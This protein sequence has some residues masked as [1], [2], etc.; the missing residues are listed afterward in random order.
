ML[1]R[2]QEVLWSQFSSGLLRWSALVMSD[3]T[4]IEKVRAHFSETSE[5]EQTRGSAQQSHPG[6]G[7]ECEA[8]IADR[9]GY[10]HR[11]HEFEEMSPSVFVLLFLY[12]HVAWTCIGKPTHTYRLCV[13]ETYS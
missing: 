2:S 13:F 3:I 12:L 5:S 8:Y 1:Y 6:T 9:Y 11:I 10:S 4:S 7:T